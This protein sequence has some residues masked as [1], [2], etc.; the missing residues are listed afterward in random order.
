MYV[1]MDIEW[2]QHENE[3]LWPT[4]IAAM[5]V[6][7]DW[8]AQDLFYTRIQP[9]DPEFFIWDHVG[10]TGGYANE[11]LSAPPLKEVCSQLF[12]W[13]K[14]GDILCWWRECSDFMVKS[15]RTRTVSSQKSPEISPKMRIWD[16]SMSWGKVIFAHFVG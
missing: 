9:A 6:D 14:P 1:L 3:M 15:G 7:K 8:N 5:R 4:Q 2:V 13:L 12:R 11:F 16:I 10:Y